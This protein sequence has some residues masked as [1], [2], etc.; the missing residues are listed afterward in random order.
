MIRCAFARRQLGALMI[1]LAAPTLALAGQYQPEPKWLDGVRAQKPFLPYRL[2]VVEFKEGTSSEW[3][4]YMGDLRATL[5][6]SNY[7]QPS[8]APRLRVEIERG[9]QHGSTNSDACKETA[10]TL[11]LTYRFF[12]GETEVNRLSIATPAPVDGDSNN[13]NAAMAGNLKFLLLGLRKGQG[14]ALFDAQAANFEARIRDDLGKG[15][16]FGCTMGTMLARGFIATVEGTIAVVGG[17]GEVAGAAMEVAASPQ[18]ASAMNSAMAEQQQ[19]RAQQQAYTNNL[20]A[21][22]QAQ[23]RAQADKERQQR[24]AQ[25]RAAE[26]QQQAGR[27]AFAKQL[28]DGIAYRNQQINKTTDPATLQRLR[29]DNE[30]ALK[31]AGQIGMRSQVDGMA[32]QTTLA[33]NAQTRTQQAADQQAE[34][35]RIADQAQKQ[36]E[37]EAQQRAEQQRI[38]A[39]KAEAERKRKADE[40]EAERKR[41]AEE[42]RLAREREAEQRRLAAEKLEQDKKLAWAEFYGAHKRSIRLGAKQCDGKEQP[43]RLIGDGPAIRMPEPIKHYSSCIKVHYEARCPSTPRGAGLRGAQNN[44]VGGGTGCLSAEEKMSQ[45]LACPAEDVIVDMVDVTA[46]H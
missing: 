33:Q 24:E 13:W 12:D 9:Y 16:N 23:Q 42:A 37:L 44:F 6:G 2:G 40:A 43:Y 17:V 45:R 5:R 10:G 3:L 39:E 31:A 26:A 11:A 28:A 46:C 38:A 34:K 15:S 35:Q 32:T 30:A 19:Q 20:N 21:Q 4:E 7:F 18:F 25:Q 14:D 27:E 36:R 8:D 41:K 22:I 1:L 29:N